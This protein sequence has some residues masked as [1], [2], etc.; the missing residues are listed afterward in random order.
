M[1]D[2]NTHF[3]LKTIILALLCS[4]DSLAPAG[5]Q[6]V[7]GI[8]EVAPG[9][10][11]GSIQT[12][13]WALGDDLVVGDTA[14]G[15]LTIDAGG[16]VSNFWAY[17]G[18]HNG[19][20]GTVIVSGSDGGGNASRWTSSDQVLIG[21]EAGS[22]GALSILGGGVAHSD[23]VTIGYDSGSIGEA[24]VSGPGS[25]WTISRSSGFLIG[26]GGAGT[27]QIDNGG[28]VHSGQG[29]IGF[30]SGSDGHVVVSDPGSIWD[31][32]GNIY[33]G[34]EGDGALEVRNGATVSTAGPSASS[35][36]AT[37]YIGFGA[38]SSGT[39]TVSGSPAHTSTL[40]ATDRI[41]VG[42][43]GAGALTVEKGGFAQ[44][45]RDTHIAIGSTAT[46]TLMLN[47]DAGGRGVLETGSVTK[48]AGAATL[49][50]DG[51]V[52]RANRDE[53][54]FLAGFATQ[55]VGSE[56]AWFD[57][58]AHDIAIATAFSGTSSFNKL[59]D[60]TLTLTGNSAAF[61]GNTEIRAGTLEVDGV[62]G[63]PAKVSAGGRLTGTGRVGP[64]A[65]SGTI[66]PGPRSG[67]GA[68]T[69]A[70]DYAAQGGS[71][72]IRTRLDGDDS[73]TDRLVITGA[74]SGATP[75]WITK[76]GGAGAQTRQGIQVV[77]V[78]GASAGRFDLANGDYAIAG[79]P[80][81]VAGAYGYVLQKDQADGSWYLR[82]SLRAVESSDP[83]GGVA[84]PGG[85]SG[86]PGAGDAPLYQPGV[87]VYE[88]YANTLLSL[89]RL[90][91]LRQRV[92][93]RLY[94]SADTG[95]NGVWGRLEGTI[96]HLEPSVSTSGEHQDI[97][98]WKAQFGV[99]RILS[100]EP[101]GSRLVGGF[102]VHY[103]TA[104][105][106]LSS[107]HGGGR[108]DTR[109]YG[110]GPTLTWYGKDGSYV[111]TQAQATWLDSD[112]SSRLAG[113][114]ADGRNAHGYAFSVEAGKPVVV[115]QGFAAIPQAQL[116]YVRT[117]FGRF[118]DKFGARIGS[119]TG[120]SMQGRIG[121]ALDY[122][123]SWKDAAGRTRQVSFYG[124]ANIK[125]EFLDGTRVRVSGVPVD[126]RLKRTWGSMGVGG[127]YGWGNGYAIYGE[128]AADT[129]L[130]G[131]HI[132][133]A[134][135]GFR[136]AF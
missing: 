24:L 12:P 112:L 65:N 35:P 86:A 50:I 70:G 19:G 81:L 77:Q 109:A 127:N 111:D 62:L 30:L 89:S 29:S 20:S 133:T 136:M 72:E 97:D 90:P 76:A 3:A 1:A 55:A 130:S 98:S 41:E 28:A 2:N 42:T 129:D 119:D 58:N 43:S 47:G 78:D 87:P 33:V 108:I 104:D 57:T 102:A 9:S 32:V 123:R 38:G 117:G 122:Q 54:D 26:S 16:T 14:S 44:A 48:G 83:G 96:S 106:R 103:G 128:V 46:G 13:D 75:V 132:V 74:T 64:T 37:L 4:A 59:G 8:G 85:G 53:P 100:G 120:D 40:A 6:S 52:L 39:V 95:R 79:Q 116:G 113:R 99:D 110:L 93:N 125:H 124:S 94:D 105:T 61:T 107:S 51:G 22:H 25:T 73:P 69:V 121:V 126:S 92:G 84:P 45:G 68:L 7:T 114:L 80:A 63:G 11:S 82:S 67:F 49:G 34:L 60:G 23:S 15:T 17:I 88:A 66:A 115:R 27:L 118:S 18:N 5:A 21:V 134:L 131:S 36:A 10:G 91:T 31:P 101:G 135:A 71:L 56:G